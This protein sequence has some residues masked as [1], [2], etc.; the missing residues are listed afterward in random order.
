MRLIRDERGGWVSV[1]V[2]C[3]VEGVSDVLRCSYFCSVHEQ[4]EQL[5]IS[6]FYKSIIAASSIYMTLLK[7]K[8]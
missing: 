8:C 5:I 6:D 1:W 7:I 2:W 4:E 3:V